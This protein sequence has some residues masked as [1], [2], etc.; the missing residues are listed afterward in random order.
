MP[1]TKQ[2]AIELY[3]QYHDKYLTTLGKDVPFSFNK[4]K[5]RAGVCFYDPIEIQISE[6]YLESKAVTEKDVSNTL[7]HEI[8]HAIAGHDAGHGPKWKHIAK[9]IGCNGDRC[10]KVFLM[11]KRYKYTLK[12]SDGCVMK[13]HKLKRNKLYVCKKH[14]KIFLK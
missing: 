10:N 9:K 1:C 7:L 12:C 14:Q 5:T 3:R 6:Y 4:N 8:A 2:R 11:G 13:R